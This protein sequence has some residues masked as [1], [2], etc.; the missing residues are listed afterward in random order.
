M[1][2]P[3]LENWLQQEQERRPRRSS[4]ASSWP[5]GRARPA[6]RAVAR[7]PPQD[8]DQRPAQP[9]RQAR[10][11]LSTNPE[12]SRAV[13]RRG[14]PRRRLGQAGPRPRH[15][16][17]PAAARQGAQRRAGGQAKVLDNKEL[18]GHR[19]RPGLR[20]GRPSTTS[21]K[22]RY[23]KVILLTD[24][25]SD[26]HH[27]ATLLLTFFYRHLRPAHRDG[28]VYLACRR[29]T[30]ST[31]ARRRTGRST[32]P[33]ATA[34]SSELAKQRQARHHPLQG[35]GRDDRR[36]CCRRRRSTRRPA[37]CLRVDHRRRARH[38]PHHQRPDG[39]GRAR[40]RFKFITERAGEVQELDV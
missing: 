2:R 31:S 16:G 26:G 21:A 39:Q 13:H 3:A 19:Q 20:H 23:G 4:R 1:V 15:P 33:T 14:R 22:L 37:G 28:R 30:R 17:D 8:G 34:S 12:E 10:R 18:A 32:T 38:R 5:P 24:A 11:L 9:A 6:A 35:P 27:I 40:A 7:R 36:R 25:D 29:S